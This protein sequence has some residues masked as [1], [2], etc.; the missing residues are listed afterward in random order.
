LTD[1]QAQIQELV[2]RILGEQRR[3]GTASAAQA[4]GLCHAQHHE[5]DHVAGVGMEL[6]VLVR[7]IK[8][9]IHTPDF[10]DKLK[11]MGFAMTW[12]TPEKYAENI[13]QELAKYARAVKVANLQPE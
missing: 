13:R 8:S 2:R 3:G 9:A 5:A 10:L 1:D 11:T 7:H 12:G 4:A 6:E